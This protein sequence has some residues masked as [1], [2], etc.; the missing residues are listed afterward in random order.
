M[1][2]NILSLPRTGSSYLYVT[3]IQNLFEINNVNEY[4]IPEPFATD[5]VNPHLYKK[6][7]KGFTATANA[8]TKNHSDQ[9]QFLKNNF[10]DLYKQFVAIDWFT[11]CILR[12]NLF[13]SAL[14]QTI[15]IKTNQFDSYDYEGKLRMVVPIEQFSTRIDEYFFWWTMIA[16]NEFNLDYK[17]VVYYED[18]TFNSLEDF[19][20]LDI[21][22]PAENR[23]LIIT[24]KSPEKKDI[25][26]NYD[27]LR[28]YY[29]NYIKTK[30]CENIIIN[31][32]LLRLKNEY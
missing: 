9:L 20:M 17:K 14:S 29:N 8:A 11:V 2:I 13:E 21:C 23:P 30:N 5:V 16:N 28:E 31:D 4:L 18:L 24:Q 10:S 25:I 27:E 1:K 15:S 6:H 22:K 3:V 19:K 26:E 12:R 32:G 7:I